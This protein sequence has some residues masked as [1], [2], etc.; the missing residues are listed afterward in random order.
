MFFLVYNLCPKWFCTGWKGIC[1]DQKL[2]GHESNCKNS[3][4]KLTIALFFK[5]VPNFLDLII[6][7]VYLYNRKYVKSPSTYILVAVMSFSKH[8]VQGLFGQIR[9]I[10]RNWYHK[11]VNWPVCWYLVCIYISKYS[12]VF[13]KRASS[14]NNSNY[15]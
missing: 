10:F 6:H 14:H 1:R 11:G 4:I 2:L 3:W 5:S 13:I 15:W 9:S 7:H 8:H 12:Q